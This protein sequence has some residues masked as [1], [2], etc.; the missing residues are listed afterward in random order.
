[1]PIGLNLT[2]K[3]LNVKVILPE[4][5]VYLNSSIKGS[6]PTGELTP[7]MEYVFQ[8]INEA[9]VFTFTINYEYNIFWSGLRSTFLIGGVIFM[10]GIL[11]YSS[12]RGKP[13]TVMTDTGATLIKTFTENCD[14]RLMLWSEIDSLEDN[15]D[16]KGIGRRDFNRRKIALRQRLLTLNR[17]LTKLKAEVRQ[18]NPIYT[19]LIISLETAETEI[20]V[21]RE[22]IERSR[23]QYRSGRL[24]RRTYT[25]L[26]EGYKKKVEDAK[27]V[28]ENTVIDLKRDL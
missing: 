15:F 8:N 9:Q 21:L 13:E 22:N 24:P 27:R 12:R 18:S 3:K 26:K 20:A 28:I 11:I 7:T 19:E 14:E 10:I 4:G 25:K 23:T 1:L 5:A 16:D 2:I 17:T 6:I